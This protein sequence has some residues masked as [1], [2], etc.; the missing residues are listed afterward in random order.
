MPVYEYQCEKCRHRFELKQ[1]FKDSSKVT[2]PQCG[3][4]A[5][6]IFS[7]VP[8]IFKGP[9][10]Y[11]TDSRQAGGEAPKPPK[12]KHEAKPDSAKH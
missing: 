1:G 5:K 7:P 9:G 4:K 6:R 3:S 12:P 8:I 2:C 10:F 11:T